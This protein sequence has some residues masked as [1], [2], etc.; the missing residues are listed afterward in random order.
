MRFTDLSGSRR[1][2]VIEW[3]ITYS[4]DNEPTSRVVPECAYAIV[5]FRQDNGRGKRQWPVEWWPID[6]LSSNHGQRR[7]L[8]A[9]GA[10][11]H[12]PGHQSVTGEPARQP[13]DSLARGAECKWSRVCLRATIGL[14]AGSQRS[15]RTASACL[16]GCQAK[17]WPVSVKPPSTIIMTSRWTSRNYSPSAAILMTGKIMSGYIYAHGYAHGH[18]YGYAYATV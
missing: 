12:L 18:G 13:P 14:V 8:L 2:E 1:G 17:S 9:A 10:D 4:M 6:G 5:P 16:I 15:V 3:I 11:R 7:Q